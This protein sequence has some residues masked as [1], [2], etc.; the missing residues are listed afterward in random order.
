[1]R[2]VW[3]TDQN[4]QPKDD[5]ALIFEVDPFGLGVAFLPDSPRNRTKLAACLYSEKKGCHVVWAIEDETVKREINAIVK[6]MEADPKLKEA[7]AQQ[8]RDRE[9]NQRLM[10]EAED[11][12]R[13]RDVNTLDDKLKIITDALAQLTTLQLAQVKGIVN[14]VAEV[15]A[16][17][18]VDPVKTV[19]DPVRTVV[20]PVKPTEAAKPVVERTEPAF[21]RGRPA[22]RIVRDEKPVEAGAAGEEIFT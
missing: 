12:R 20:E 1:M 9:E 16:V 19:I 13:G 15:K 3:A 17:P 2:A 7:E 11:R 18:V 21:R 14:Q 8:A 4:G 22:E 10:K 6:Q 5:G